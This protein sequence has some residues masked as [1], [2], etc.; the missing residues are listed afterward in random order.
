MTE[1]ELD[2]DQPKPQ[3]EIVRYKRPTGSLLL[4]LSG[5]LVLAAVVTFI[6]GAETDR[7]QSET[8]FLWFLTAACALQLS[9]FL[10]LA[11]IIVRAIWFLPGEEVKE[12]RSA[13]R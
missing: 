13:Q 5:I 2:R 11:G 6:I 7:Y 10:G 8:R 3:I 1:S 4:G 9:L 12:D